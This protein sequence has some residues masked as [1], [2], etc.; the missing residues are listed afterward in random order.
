MTAIAQPPRS[1]R[2][3]SAP[4]GGDGQPSGARSRALLTAPVARVVGLAALGIWAADRW[5]ILVD[6]SGTP[7]MLALLLLALATGATVAQLA[8]LPATTQAPAAVGVVIV[9]TATSLIAAGAPASDVL[10][11]THWDTLALGLQH[12]VDVL[13]SV[14]VPY[15][16][17]EPW[18]R[19]AILLS[20]A[21]LLTL[22]CVLGLAPGRHGVPFRDGAPFA[23][24]FEL[25][26][27]SAV[28]LVAAAVVPAAILTPDS[29]ALEGVVLMIVVVAYLWLE[30]LSRAQ[31]PGALIVLA[32]A[33]LAGAVAT[34]L[35]DR[36]EPWI[37]VQHLVDRIDR[38]A[39]TSFD[40]TQT[41]G[42]LDWPRTGREVLR[43]RSNV[44]SYW[45]AE[46]L[47]D[48][49]GLRWAPANG[50]AENALAEVPHAALLRKAWQHSVVVTIGDF[51]TP[52]AVAAGTTVN[53]A[54]EGSRFTGGSSPGTWVAHGALRPGETYV[55]ES[56]VP[57]PKDAQLLGS[58]TDYPQAIASYLKVGL[59]E[60]AG[61]GYAPGTTSVQLP[62][63]G[64]GEA[65]FAIRQQLALSPY[66]GVYSLARRLAA[67]A[68]TPYSY[69]NRVLGYLRAGFTY[70]EEPPPSKVPLASFLLRDRL[71]YCQQFAGAAALL[72]RLGGVPARVSTGFTSG[73]RDSNGDYVVR[74]YDA[75]A[76]IEVWFPNIGWA[77]YDPTPT[78]APALGGRVPAGGTVT[79]FRA[80]VV[81]RRLPPLRQAPRRDSGVAAPVADNGS[82]FPWI[83]V[84]VIAVLA[85]A[86][87]AALLWTLRAPV[88]EEALLAELERALRRT[89]RPPKP[90]TT[91]L[92]LEHRF[93]DSPEAAAYVRA[94]RMARYA[95]GEATVTARQ[96]RALR[97]ELARGLGQLGRIRALFALPP[98][99]RHR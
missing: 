66:A 68:T 33:C 9:W 31:L 59:P 82:S 21:L 89:G 85:A 44:D 97:A 71:G 76:W 63:F 65:E 54:G 37:D 38:P 6:P 46:N 72:L 32:V 52:D 62:A 1:A 34:P 79:P 28:P 17:D 95:E 8:R 25:R 36:G 40:W 83:P 64:A 7:R 42:P 27:M 22:G 30:R 93:H 92:Q 23:G 15:S 91:L 49:D 29:P 24:G 2:P 20:G 45:K 94:V 16:V 84:I 78:A 18:P 39:A 55:A 11:P 98:R 48:F 50:V 51:S 5:G 87:L 10:N 53:F 13:P 60:H 77:Q 19:I 96:R 75:H 69:L 35:L 58:G 81:P 61:N 73:S 47:D 74:D 86:A 80:P 12:G 99:L 3:A 26:L 4:A 67:S 43:V 41:Y 57:R 56:I 90:K 70:S 14:I 88:G